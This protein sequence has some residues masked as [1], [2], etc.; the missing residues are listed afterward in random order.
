MFQSQEAKMQLQL[1]L[2]LLKNNK[3]KS[4]TLATKL[5]SHK[6]EGRGGETQ[7]ITTEVKNIMHTEIHKK[8]TYFYS[9]VFTI[10]LQILILFASGSLVLLL[11]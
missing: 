11:G 2:T 6:G 7:V 10:P 9:L 8:K 1:S 5:A 3:C 4:A